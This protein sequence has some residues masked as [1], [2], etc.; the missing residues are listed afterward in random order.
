MNKFFKIFFK[1]LIISF[2]ILFLSVVIAIGAFLFIGMT[3]SVADF[4]ITIDTN[5]GTALGGITDASAMSTYI[6][7]MFAYIF[8][9]TAEAA[10]LS[11][12][13]DGL[14][15]TI[16]IS[17]MAGGSAILGGWIIFS[18]LHAVTTKK[19]AGIYF[20]KN[21][22]KQLDQLER[23]QEKVDMKVQWLTRKHR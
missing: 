14:V 19:I 10:A 16:S 21:Y 3:K 5:M 1:T 6:M 18:F 23:V 9:P 12:K 17:L 11:T 7:A 15:E 2:G 4:G 22:D 13:L 8:A 20:S